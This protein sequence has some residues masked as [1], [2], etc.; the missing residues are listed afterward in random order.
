MSEQKSTSFMQELDQWAD[1]YVISPLVCSDGDGGEE[2]TDET[3][4]HVKFAI[5]EKVLES[6]KNG[7]K[8]GAGHVRR[9]YRDGGRKERSYAQARSH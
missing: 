2:I 5:R 3:V 4:K 7:C 9:E 6:Y 1:A 8:A